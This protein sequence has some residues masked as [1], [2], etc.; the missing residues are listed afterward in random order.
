VNK[1]WWSSL[2]SDVRAQLERALREATQYA[3]QIA[4]E[5]NEEDLARVRAAGTTE[6]HVATPAERLALKRALLPVHA[7]MESRIG[8]DLLQA[9]YRATGFQPDGL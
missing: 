9:I 8:R 7:R 4:G 5:K 1:R 6:V 3:N 2:P